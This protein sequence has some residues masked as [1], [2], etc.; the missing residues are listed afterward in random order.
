MDSIYFNSIYPFY[1]STCAHKYGYID[2]FLTGKNISNTKWLDY[3]NI[4]WIPF[5][6][7]TFFLFP[8]NQDSNS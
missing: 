5:L 7:S 3:T 8:K 1:T 2:N 4:K 6:D